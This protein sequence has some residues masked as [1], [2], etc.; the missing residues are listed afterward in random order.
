M[1]NE[2]RLI[3]HVQV[4]YGLGLGNSSDSAI[5]I[6]IRVTITIAI[7]KNYY[8]NSGHVA[9]RM[10]SQNCHTSTSHVNKRAKMASNCGDCGEIVLDEEL[11]VLPLQGSKSGVWQYFGFFATDG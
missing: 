2:S 3:F 6:V 11:E 9:I 1:H 8:R 5:I 4:Y 7:G 10:R